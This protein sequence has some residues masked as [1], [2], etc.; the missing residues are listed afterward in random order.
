VEAA[1][2][3]GAE[4]EARESQGGFRVR[5]IIRFIAAD[6]VISLA[7]GLFRMAGFFSSADAFITAVLGGKLVLFA[8]LAWLIGEHRESWRE[9]GALTL[10]RPLG[11]LLALV[12]YGLAYPLLEAA[13]SLNQAWLAMAYEWLGLA[14]RPAGQEVMQYIFSDALGRPLR[15]ILLFFVILAGPCL[16]EMAF[17]GMGLD[18]FRRAGGALGALVWTSLLFGMFH[19]SPSIFLP[20]S[21]L[22]LVFGLARMLSGSLWCGLT[23]H[24]LHNALTL[25][26][27]ARALGWL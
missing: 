12:T 13:D 5:D 3:D 15:L 27:A 4:P 23:L 10:G 9:T 18:A 1:R 24:S 22:G 20:L 19:F 17:R 14:Y 6:I 11:W 21:L 7:V 26:L 2:A 25:F 16:E 8:Y